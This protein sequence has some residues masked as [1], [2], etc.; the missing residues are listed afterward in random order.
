MFHV[1]VPPSMIFQFIFNRRQKLL[2]SLAASAAVPCCV[3]GG[4]CHSVPSGRLTNIVAILRNIKNIGGNI[5][6]IQICPT[7]SYIP[8]SRG[9]LVYLVNKST[10]NML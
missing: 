7:N 8:P 1:L 2:S 4:H 5:T 10:Y 6:Y 9:W 3:V